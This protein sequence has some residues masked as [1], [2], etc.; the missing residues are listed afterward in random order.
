MNNW[1]VWYHHI[2]D[3]WTINGY[4]KIYKI[5]SV[6]KFWELYNSWDKLGGL[7]SK[8]FFIMKENITPL[9]ED[10]M[11]KNGGCWSIKINVNIAKEMWEY[12]SILMM[13]DKLYNYNNNNN[14]TINGLSICL[15]KNNICIIK[16]WIKENNNDIKLLNKEIFN[17]YNP[18]LLFI[19][20]NKF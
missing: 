15:K 3:D 7:L 17:K 10:K 2:K 11:N 8:Q 1:F 20:N 6:K 5:N 13:I 14:D 9:W 4:K 16:L 18:E 19:V 12:L